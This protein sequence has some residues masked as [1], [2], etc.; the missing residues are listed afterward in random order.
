MCSWG[1]EPWVSSQSKRVVS[2]QYILAD[3]CPGLLLLVGGRA[4]G[5]EDVC[6]HLPLCPQIPFLEEW[7]PGLKTTGSRSAQP[8]YTLLM[9]PVWQPNVGS[10]GR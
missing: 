9:G 4:G 8:I 3:W 2:A 1:L 5:G 7:L 10:V 6:S